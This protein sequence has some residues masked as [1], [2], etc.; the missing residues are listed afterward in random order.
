MR[1]PHHRRQPGAGGAH[2]PRLPAA[3]LRVHAAARRGHHPLHALGGAAGHVGGGGA[4][5]PAG[6]GQDPAHLPR[7]G[8]GL[9]QGRA[10][11]HQHRPGPLHHDG[12]D[13]GPEAGGRV[14]GDAALVLLLGT[15]VAQAP[16]LRPFW[17]D[18]ITK[19]ELENELDAALQLPGISNA[20]T[21]PI[22]GRLD[23]LSTGIRTPIGIKIAGRRPRG[24]RAGGHRDRGG[25]GEGARDAQR[26][27]RAGGGRLLP[28]LRARA[29]R[30]RPLRAQ[31]RRRQP[32][33]DD[34][35]GRRRPE[36][37]GRGPGAVRRSTSGTRAT[38]ATTSR[39]CAACSSPCRA[40]DRSRWRRSPT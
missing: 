38:T 34:G 32:H 13:R 29:R 11:Q 2:H 30:A 39:A 25:A 20:W 22:K 4:A 36:H 24:D 21:M 6:A 5:R 27:R 19:A 35:G 28:R 26:V 1:K 17:R 9:R 23:M 14:A 16:A 33:G 18:R 31:R 7:G 3:R 8:A 40:A 10:R 15:A 12:D 37:D